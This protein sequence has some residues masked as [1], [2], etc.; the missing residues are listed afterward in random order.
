MKTQHL[1]IFFSR[2]LGFYKSGGLLKEVIDFNGGRTIYTYDAN[3]R[4]TSITRPNGTS[5]TA[6]Y[7]V[8]GQIE[9]MT[10]G[11]SAGT[12]TTF[13]FKYDALGNILEEKQKSEK[14]A[15]TKGTVN[16]QYGKGN[17][18]IKFYGEDVTY[19]SDGNMTYGPLGSKMVNFTYNERNRLRQVGRIG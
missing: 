17:R 8:L 19:D 13:S 9:T 1:I 10:Y 2:I 15:I 14:A 5:S 3:R 12:I 18:L 16:L 7:N 11:G 4:G 6:R